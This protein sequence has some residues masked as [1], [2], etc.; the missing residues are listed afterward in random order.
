MVRY[1]EIKKVLKSHNLRITDGRIDILEFMFREKRT[2]S[3]KDLE[4]EFKSLDRVTLYR[5]LKTFT[6]HGL[7]HKIPDDSGFATYG[8][9]HDSCNS[10]KHYH[11]HIH[12][13]CN[14]C[15]VIEC[16]EQNVPT[17][18][19]PNYIIKEAD[20]ILRGVCKTC[21]S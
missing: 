14:E 12:F 20:L 11:D 8:I 19:I 18:K 2:L 6:E 9:C 16:L 13:K 7:L 21:V 15:G 10:E 4:G 5:T 17:I 1:S 3:M